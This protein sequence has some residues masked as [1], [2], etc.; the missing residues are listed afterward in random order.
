[1]LLC[2]LLATTVFYVG[3]AT[4]LTIQSLPFLMVSCF[5][6]GLS[7]SNIVLAQSAIADTAER[8]DRNR[9]FGYVY[10]SASLAYVVG[11]LGGGQLADHG[12][13]SWFSYATPYWAVTILL[14]AVFVA[15]SG[16]FRET[17]PGT[18]EKVTPWR[19]SPTSPA[20]SRIADCALSI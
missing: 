3:I 17:H 20:S 13:V 15:V 8:D 5:L 10:L 4:A 19:P 12:L 6:A 9:L 7:E 16:W 2:S 18:G 14:G 1:M 11:P